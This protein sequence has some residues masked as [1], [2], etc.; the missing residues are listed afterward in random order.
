MTQFDTLEIPGGFIIPK[1]THT[2]KWQQDTGR[3]DHDE[4]L[5]PFAV[6]RL[7]PGDFV[8]DCG[9][10]DGDHTIAYSKAVGELGTVVAVEA[11]ELAYH[12]LSHNI[13]KF[14]IK[15]VVAI[16]AAVED[17]SAHMVY[18]LPNKN[19]GA[20]R[21]VP[22]PTG[23]K[24]I[25]SITIDEIVGRIGKFP[26]FIKLDVEGYEYFAL[27]G[28]TKTIFNHRPELLIEINRGALKDTGASPELIMELLEKHHYSWKIVQPN[29]KFYDPQYDIHCTPE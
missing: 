6:S 15:N 17:I 4:F 3:L 18:H 9:A 8:I 24:P 14:P 5:I 7:N 27:C 20:S 16:N 12:C 22:Y 29:V 2:G 23:E 28:A 11:G 19:V 26:R 21:V 13:E 1:D 10:F 25:A